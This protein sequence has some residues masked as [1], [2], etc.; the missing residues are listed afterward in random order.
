MLGNVKM[1]DAA[2]VVGQHDE[3]KEHAEVNR[4]Y[5]EEIAGMPATWVTAAYGRVADTPP[6]W[7]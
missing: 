6:P 5:G 2:S 1:H 3:D 7:I 4:G